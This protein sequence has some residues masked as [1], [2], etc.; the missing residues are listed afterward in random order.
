MMF[1]RPFLPGRVFAIS[2]LLVL[3]AFVA[4]FSAP[5]RGDGPPAAP[6]PDKTKV[7]KA[8]NPNEPASCPT[9]FLLV[10]TVCSSSAI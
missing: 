1:C 8:P 10:P 5:A 6:L 2:S 4:V 7:K 9:A 3:G